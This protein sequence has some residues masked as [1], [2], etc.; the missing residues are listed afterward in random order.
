MRAIVPV[1]VLLLAG[2]AAADHWCL[3]ADVITAEPR[4]GGIQVK[5][6]A[7]FYN[8]CP[9]PIVYDLTVEGDVL[10]LTETALEETP[11]DCLCCFDLRIFVAGVAPGD[12]T[13]RFR[14]YDLEAF[15][16][17]SRDVA[18]TVPPAAADGEPAIGETTNSGCLAQVGIGGPE[19]SYGSWGGLKARYR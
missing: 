4:E 17:T 16:W 9:D 11:C 14:W 1:L 18:V 2:G 10:I 8:C 6:L 13:L 3:D 5:H 15:E 19:S 7:A 12:W